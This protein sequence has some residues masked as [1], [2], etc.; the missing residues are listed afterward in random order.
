MLNF[1]FKKSDVNIISMRTLTKDAINKIGDTVTLMG[2]VAVRRDHGKLIFIDLRDRWGIVQVVFSPK[3]VELLK[4]ADRLR[5]EWVVKI[6]G[7]V[8]ERPKGMENTEL[9]TGKIEV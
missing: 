2:W 1:L 6:E 9:P 7:A 4:E 3:D 5:P 8:K